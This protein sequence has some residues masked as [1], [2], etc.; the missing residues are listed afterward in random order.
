[1]L[2]DEG[3]LFVTRHILNIAPILEDDWRRKS[4]FTHV[5]PSMVKYVMLSLM[6][7]I[8]RMWCLKLWWTN[9]HL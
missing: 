1:M 8:V 4:S 2:Y 9:L 7:E 3:K 5:T 6:V